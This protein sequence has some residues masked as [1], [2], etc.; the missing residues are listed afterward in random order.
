M[1]F[2]AI[3]HA[4]DALLVRS[5]RVMGRVGSWVGSWVGLLVGAPVHY[6]GRLYLER[7]QGTISG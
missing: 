2:L 6:G 3:K 7:K 1:R 5:C 4:M